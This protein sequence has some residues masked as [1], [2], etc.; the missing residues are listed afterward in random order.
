[1]GALGAVDH[2]PLAMLFDTF[3]CES[4]TISMLAEPDGLRYST[5]EPN[6]I[7]FPV[8][9]MITD[10][11]PQYPGS[12]VVRIEIHVERIN[13]T[14]A[15]I[16]DYDSAAGGSRGLASAIWLDAVKPGRISSDIVD[17]SQVHGMPSESIERVEVAES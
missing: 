10:F 3:I 5:E 1:M 11:L 9:D 16:V 6:H 13:V 7:M 17:G 4:F 15:M 2:G 8:P 12:L 14:C